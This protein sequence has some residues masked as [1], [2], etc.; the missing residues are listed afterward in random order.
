MVE[1]LPAN[2]GDR[3]SG[4]IPRLGRSPGEGHGN[5]LQYGQR[6]LV[7]CGPED[8]KESDTS[9]HVCIQDK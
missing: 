9:L 3:D 5:S 1:D 6:S 8:R 4:S 2:V 7:G